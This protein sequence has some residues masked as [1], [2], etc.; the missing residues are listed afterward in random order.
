MSLENNEQEHDTS[1]AGKNE[2]N[3]K[4]SESPPQMSPTA[5]PPDPP[6]PP[7]APPSADNNPSKWRE[8][9]KIGLE[10][11]G[12]LLLFAYTWF[13][14]LQWL[15]I[16]WTNRLTRE[17]L[18]DNDKTLSQTLAKLQGQIDAT[19]VLAGHAKDQADHAAVM[20]TNSGTQATATTNAAIAAKSAADTA[21]EALH[22]TER[23]YI[24]TGAPVLNMDTRVVAIPVVN[25]GHIPSGDVKMIVHEA[26]INVD[27]NAPAGIFIPVE[28]HWQHYNESSLPTAGVGGVSFTINTP[29]T[30]VVTEK[31]NDGHQQ[32][33]IAG[34]ISYN[35]GF[36]DRPEQTWLFCVGGLYF[37]KMKR[38]DWTPCDA[39]HY[40]NQLTSGDHYPQNEYSGWP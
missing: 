39:E 22:T 3:K 10:I 17:A 20:A 36:P 2:A 31:M 12:V 29:V 27:P 1:N 28:Q 34:S 13:T 21:K 35:D 30:G 18:N 40:I 4:R 11:F 19:N 8:N 7:S 15:Q 26:T 16:R 37:Q 38:I 25:T 33:I 23:A 24:S 14:C 32:I 9:T 6:Q 5:P